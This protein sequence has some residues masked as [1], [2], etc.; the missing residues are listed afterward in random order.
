MIK[1]LHFQGYWIISEVEEIDGLE[2]GDPD[3]M[4]K[5]PYAVEQGVL[6][7]WPPYSTEKKIIV[8]SSEISVMVDPDAP[9]LADYAKLKSEET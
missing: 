2:F 1:I 4:L 5:Y 3:C 9:R 7:P 8:R 6:V